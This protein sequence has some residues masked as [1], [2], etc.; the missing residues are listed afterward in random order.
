MPM[1]K[2]WLLV[3][4]RSGSDSRTECAV[5]AIRAIAKEVP[6]AIVGAGTVLNHSSWRKSWK[7]VHSSQLAGSDRA[8]LK[9]ATEDYSSN[10]RDQHCFQ[11]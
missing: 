6:E 11:D 3:G 8:L 1:A 2:R 9:A 5:D 4:A 10:S 7:R